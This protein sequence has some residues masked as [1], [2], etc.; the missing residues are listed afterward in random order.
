M[1]LLRGSR[2][3]DEWAGDTAAAL[4]A[5]AGALVAVVAGKA[6]RQLAGTRSGSPTTTLQLQL[7][8]EALLPAELSEGL[9]TSTGSGVAPVS[10]VLTVMRP[11]SAIVIC[12]T[13]WPAAA[14]GL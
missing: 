3:Q 12:A 7:I 1:A 11:S 6:V 13:Y 8:G 14:A 5:L 10:L 9:R 4:V 2:A